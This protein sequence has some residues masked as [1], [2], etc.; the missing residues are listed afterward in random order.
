[1]M[2]VQ[3]KSGAPLPKHKS[4]SARFSGKSAW[5]RF[6]KRF[7]AKLVRDDGYYECAICHAWIT[8]PDVDHIIK[9]SVAPDRIYDETN[10][11]LL[12]RPCH[13]AKDGG[14]RRVA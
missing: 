5:Q 1:M 12:C 13:V 2:N 7:K 8:N 4:P 3:P 9:R 14:M 10:L 6:K 11:Q